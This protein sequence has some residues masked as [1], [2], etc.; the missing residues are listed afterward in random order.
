MLALYQLLAYTN[1]QLYLL[2][3]NPTCL[4]FSGTYFCCLEGKTNGLL[5]F[6]VSGVIVIDNK[7]SKTIDLYSAYKRNNYRRLFTLS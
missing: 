7:K 6:Q 3:K 5:K 4:H 2:S 1:M